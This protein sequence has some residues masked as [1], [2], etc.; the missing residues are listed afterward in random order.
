MITVIVWLMTFT[1]RSPTQLSKKKGKSQFLCFD[2]FWCIT[3]YLSKGSGDPSKINNNLTD[4]LKFKFKITLRTHRLQTEQ[5][6]A[7]FGLI[8]EHFG[9]LKIISPS[10]NPIC[11]IF[12]LVALPNCTA[13]GSENIDLRW[14]DTAKKIPVLKIIM[15]I[16]R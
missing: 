9:H 6:C 12:S 2:V 10:R 13:P 11:W 3:T 16:I 4:F 8:E 5:W 14:L 15:L 1:Y 7:R